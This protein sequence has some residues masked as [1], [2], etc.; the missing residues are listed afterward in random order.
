MNAP[1]RLKHNL[2]LTI[3]KDGNNIIAG[4][5]LSC[6]DQHDFE[7][8]YQGALKKTLFGNQYLQT[9]DNGLILNARCMICGREVIVFNSLTDG[10][11]RCIDPTEHAVSNTQLVPYGCPRCSNKG[12]NINL[13][14]ECLSKEEIDEE[15]LEDYENSFTWVNVSLKCTDCGKEINKIID[16]ETA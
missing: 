9:D 3:I 2:E 6:C 13:E 10:Y 1:K 16:F 15:G 4:G 12:F 5:Q 8:S 14:Y 11:D 7:V